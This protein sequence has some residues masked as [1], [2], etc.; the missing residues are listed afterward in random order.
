L[1]EKPLKPLVRRSLRVVPIIPG[2]LSS[3]DANGVAVHRRFEA[4]SLRRHIFSLAC[5]G[6]APSNVY[7]ATIEDVRSDKIVYVVA[8]SYSVFECCKFAFSF[9]LLPDRC[10]RLR[11]ML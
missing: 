2:S 6:F 9:W 11:S 1:F 3:G 8:G 5:R 10:S 7:A 4:D